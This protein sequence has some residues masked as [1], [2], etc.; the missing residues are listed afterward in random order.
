MARSNVPTPAE[1]LKLLRT[2]HAAGVSYRNATRQLH[3]AEFAWRQ[4]ATTAD[5]GDP[6]HENHQVR[7]TSA[8]QAFAAADLALVNAHQALDRFHG[9]RLTPRR[10]PG[11]KQVVKTLRKRIAS[12]ERGAAA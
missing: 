1:E 7:M 5:H 4:F 12:M 10:A 11:R 6:A 3:Q 9:E 8:K 2:S